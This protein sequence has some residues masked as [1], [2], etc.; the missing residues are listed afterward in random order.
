[1]SA[2]LAEAPP[3]APRGAGGLRRRP[4]GLRLAGDEPGPRER[5]AHGGRALAGGHEGLREP[6]AAPCAGRLAA[7]AQ[8]VARGRAGAGP[9][10][11]RTPRALPPGAAL[12]PRARRR[13]GRRH[14]G[15]ADRRRRRAGSRPVRGRSGRAPR[16]RSRRV[17]RARGRPSRL[18]GRASAHCGGATGAG[19]RTSS[20]WP[21]GKDSAPTWSPSSRSPLRV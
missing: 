21:P 4:G 17:R 5:G 12:V 1:M 20:R 7:H 2:V 11:G 19:W 8:R 18:S 16:R 15:A 3:P 6:S 10:R 13:R 9:A 14:Q